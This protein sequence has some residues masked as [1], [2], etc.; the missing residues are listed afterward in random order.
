VL[1]AVGAVVVSRIARTPPLAAGGHTHVVRDVVEGMRWLWRN[2]P[3]RTLA[4][5]ITAFNVTWGAAWSMLV[6][7]AIERLR[8]GDVGYGLLLTVIAAGG[9]LGTVAYGWLERHFSLANIMRVGLIIETSTHLLLATTT[10]AWVAMATLFV[11]GVHEFV[12][13][14]TATS[15]RQR[16]VPTEFQ[17][18]V[19]SVYMV[20]VFGGL[21]VGAA[22]GGVIAQR[23]GV[24]APYW[25]AF[26]GSAV[27]LAVIWRELGNI[28]HA[29]EPATGSPV[30][31]SG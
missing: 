16:A 11:F 18:R 30:P 19:G 3:V 24:T 13:G 26:V 5:T 8:L 20:G 4:I 9:L 31:G 2:P 14:T 1:V 12:W 29:G 22:L 6:L 25:Y 10:T 27:I 17:G 21:V 28:A 15:I 7:L 23:W